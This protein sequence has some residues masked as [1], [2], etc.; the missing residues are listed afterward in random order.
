VI[1]RSQLELELWLERLLWLELLL[2]KLL[3]L[4]GL[5]LDWLSSVEALLISLCSEEAL[6]SSDDALLS[7]E[8]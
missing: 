2:E 8:E 5:P 4:E 3:W 1:S 6:L 7:S